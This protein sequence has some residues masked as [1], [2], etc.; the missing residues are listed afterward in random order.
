MNKYTTDIV[1]SLFLIAL[2]IALLVFGPLAIIWSINTLFPVAAIPYNFW[3]W[4][5]III[6]NSTWMGSNVITKK[7]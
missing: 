3:S 1:G 6:L 7:D 2:A 4:L 5:A